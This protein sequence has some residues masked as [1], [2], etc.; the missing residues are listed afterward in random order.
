M[1]KSGNTSV[2]EKLINKTK[3]LIQYNQ[4]KIPKTIQV[5]RKNSFYKKPRTI[6][7]DN[8]KRIFKNNIML[9]YISFALNNKKIEKVPIENKSR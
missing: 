5:T 4:H 2:L 3:P 7:F 1:S 9:P 6:K 8:S